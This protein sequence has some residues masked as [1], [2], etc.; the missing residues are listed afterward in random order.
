MKEKYTKMYKKLLKEFFEKCKGIQFDNITSI[1]SIFI[2]GIG[3]NYS[4]A[5]HKILYIGI[6]TND[7]FDLKKDIED[8]K[9]QG[10]D[11]I[12][13][14]ISRT[15]NFLNDIEN[16]YNNCY[17]QFWEFIFR[18]Q[19]KIYNIEYN[20]KNIIN[21]FNDALNSFAWGN[22][23]AIE[24]EEHYRKHIVGSYDVMRESYKKIKNNSK[25]FDKLDNVLRCLPEKPDL[26]IILNWSENLKYIGKEY[27]KQ[28][29]EFEKA[30]EM[31]IELYKH[32]END[33]YILWTR[34]PYSMNFYKTLFDKKKV[35]YYVDKIYDIVKN[36]QIV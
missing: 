22:S 23:N 24:K 13:K 31:K 9:L 34:H 14:Y 26:I 32:Q 16:I 18:F 5:K 20:E 17:S 21:N 2:P 25:E 35:E 1:P 10:D 8:Y 12:E 11:F 3:K 27:I 7:W 19:F 6:D 29:L 30:D 15:S 33:C 36:K 4:S 28:S